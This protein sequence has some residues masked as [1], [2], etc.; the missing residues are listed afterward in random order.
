MRTVEECLDD[1]QDD[2]F[3][4]SETLLEFMDEETAEGMLKALC[5]AAQTGNTAS[6]PSLALSLG[7]AINEAMHK[8]AAGES[9]RTRTP[10]VTNFDELRDV[11]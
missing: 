8:R 2:A 10:F 6:L 3:P 4:Y 11:A 5:Q 9:L 7:N 1:L